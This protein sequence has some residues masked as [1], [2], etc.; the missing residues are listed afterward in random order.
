DYPIYVQVGQFSFNFPDFYQSINVNLGR[1]YEKAKEVAEKMDGDYFLEEITLDILSLNENIPYSETESSCV[2]KFWNVMEIETSLKEDLEL[3]IPHIKIKGTDFSKRNDY[4]VWDALSGFDKDF[5][6]GMRYSGKW[7]MELEVFPS[8][9]GILVA[10]PF[11]DPKAKELAY[12]TPF[13]CL[14]DYN[15]IY[16]IKYP[17]LI[18]FS[19]DD[20]FVFQF[21][22]QVVIDNNQPKENILGTENFESSKPIICENAIKPITVYALDAGTY[23]TVDN[24][25]IK[26]KC[27]STV[28]QLGKTEYRLDGESKL[29]TK[30]PAC[31]NGFL[32]ADKKGY[33]TGKQIV[34]TTEETQ[35]S[36]LLDEFRELDYEI[37]LVEK[38]GLV[39]DP[40]DD[41]NVILILNEDEKEY[42]VN[43][44]P[45]YDNYKIKL[46]PGTYDFQAQ[47]ASESDEGFYIESKT[48]EK[49]VDAPKQGFWGA[50][51]GF[52]EEHCYSV[53]MPSIKL[54]YAIT[55][56]TNFE[57]AVYSQD[58]DTFSK[59]IFY[60][61]VK[62]PPKTQEDVA[63]IMEEVETGTTVF[64]PEWAI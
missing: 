30:S 9:N 53:E 24:V 13:L 47:V 60:V 55:G 23:K 3:N 18:I 56:G 49:C 35:F 14:L 43:L 39:R 26:I 22:S 21:A 1:F 42:N 48:I 50:F 29:F 10:E 7:P 52:E 31:V 11:N 62:D 25:E 46:I 2:P 6:V 59:I 41:E 20:G 45:E 44:L 19:D 57:W 34:D 17:V 54:D 61:P 37:K 5:H 38:S 63:R 15:F 32:I 51:L 58:L 28:C 36:V 27:V 8:D 4:F 64:N 40:T 12:V 16:D 33:H